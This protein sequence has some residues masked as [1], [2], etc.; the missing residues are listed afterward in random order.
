MKEE[1]LISWYIQKRKR[2][3]SVPR[4]N[5]SSPKKKDYPKDESKCYDEIILNMILR[6]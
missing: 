3:A 2:M 5:V 1:F 6:K 4:Q